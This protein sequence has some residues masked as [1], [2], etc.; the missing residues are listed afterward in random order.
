[1]PAVGPVLASYLPQLFSR[2]ASQTHAAL[3][4]SAQELHAAALFVDISGFTALAERLGARGVIGAEELTSH[5]NGYFGGLIDILHAHGGDV[6]SFA[7]DALWAVWEAEG[8]DLADAALRA[9][10]GAVE[11]QSRMIAY[12]RDVA[13]ESLSMRMGIGC[14]TVVAAQLGGVSERWATVFAGTAF[15]EATLAEGRAKPGQ[16]VLAPKAL[17]LVADRMQG[18]RLGHPPALRVQ[19]VH[20]APAPRPLPVLTI[21]DGDDAYFSAFIPQGILGRIRAGMADWLGELRQL[22]V[23][24]VHLS[25]LEGRVEVDDIQAL[26]ADTQRTIYGLEGSLNKLSVDEK[27]IT[28]L[29]AFGLPP[30]AHE[31]DP[32]RGVRAALRIH[33]ALSAHGQVTG[34]GVTTGRVFC[35]IVGNDRRREYTVIGDA[36]NLSARLMKAAEG[37]I[38]LDKATHDHLGPDLPVDEL[39]PIRLKGKAKLTPVFRPIREQV[40]AVR[41]VTRLSFVGREEELQ[42]LRCGVGEVLEGRGSTWLIEGEAGIGKSCLTDELERTALERGVVVVRVSGGAVSRST[43]WYAWRRY[44]TTLV[45][46]GAVAVTAGAVAHVAEEWGI[47]DQAPLLNPVLGVELPETELTRPMDGEVRAY[48]TRQLLS[49]LFERAVGRQPTLLLVEDAHWLDSSSTE[50]CVELAE[51]QNRMVVFVRRPPGVPVPVEARRVSQLPDLRSIQLSGLEE[52][53]AERLIGIA[54]GVKRVPAPVVSFIRDRAEGHPFYTAELALSLRDVGAISV[55]ARRCSIVDGTQL[56]RMTFPDTMHGV[57]TSR[58]D[59]LSPEEQM[60]LKVGSVVGR[61]FGLRPLQQIYPVDTGRPEIEAHADRSAER[62]LLSHQSDDDDRGWM[63]RHAITHEATYSLLPYDQRR[64]LHR[65]AAEWIERSH[66]DLTG[67]HGLLAHHW[68]LAEEPEQALGYLE[69]VIEQARRDGAYREAIHH[70][71]TGSQLLIKAPSLDS[72][73]RRATWNIALAQAF[74]GL[75]QLNAALDAARAAAGL[76]GFPMPTGTAGQVMSILTGFMRQVGGRFLPGDVRALR[77]ARAYSILWIVHFQKGEAVPTTLGALRTLNLAEA[78]G[79]ATPE[80]A[81][82]YANMALISGVVPVHRLSQ[83]Y[84]DRALQTAEQLDFVPNEAVVLEM[85]SIY[86]IGCGRWEEVRNWV[87][88]AI[89]LNERFGDRRRFDEATALHAWLPYFVGDLEE[90]V[91]RW[92]RTEASARRRGDPQPQIWGLCGQVECGLP[93]EAIELDRA[94]EY[95]EESVALSGGLIDADR[96]RAFGV[97]AWVHA[98]RGDLDRAVECGREAA[99]RIQRSN[100]TAFYSFCGRAGTGELFLRLWEEGNT[101]LR[102]MAMK[103]T[104]CFRAY[105]GVFPVGQPRASRDDGWRL[106][107]EGKHEPAMKRWREGLEIARQQGQRYEEALLLAE[108]GLRGEDAVSVQRARQLFEQMGATRDL[109]RFD[110]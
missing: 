16:V 79:G 14:G 33:E 28:L 106:W 24:F 29:A 85:I 69:E 13:Q 17:V 81:E 32:A 89:E 102:P 92:Q 48:N 9:T 1:M 12:A 47:V 67:Y 97:A 3:Q 107:L 26:M 91:H 34:I 2:R 110:A 42:A 51:P 11:A 87:E 40:V 65:A 75:G 36:V 15:V 64:M 104:K 46:R 31:D 100:P 58:V 45:A 74:Y 94:A 77:A 20:D 43:P 108:L 84:I 10:A 62:G 41:P 70:V 90:G 23:L 35:G 25:K 71:E 66:E 61:T 56:H 5:L 83:Y 72:V 22:T 19:Q 80:L 76:L 88:R 8:D 4:A 96:I 63:F 86:A 55:D 60:V 30:L 101:Y 37:G 103:V 27:G 99:E 73:D 50:L 39:A 44:F 54:L 57:V 38:L 6:V 95:V 78:A 68:T 59:R 7:G 18:E 52:D 105:G 109:A 93:I 98:H 49:R 82:A 53:Q 21:Q